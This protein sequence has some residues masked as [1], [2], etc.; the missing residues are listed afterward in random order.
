M[1]GDDNGGREDRKIA[2]C[3]AD[4]LQNSLFSSF[5]EANIGPSQGW[6]PN[7]LALDPWGFCFRKSG[8][9]PKKLYF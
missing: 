7:Y 3:R 6:S 9:G 2:T 4:P 8:I 5:H 1:Q